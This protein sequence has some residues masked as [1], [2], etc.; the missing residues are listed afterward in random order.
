MI[1]IGKLNNMVFHPLTPAQ[2]V[3]HHKREA[4]RLRQMAASEFAAENMM[5][6]CPETSGMSMELLERIEARMPKKD[7]KTNTEEKS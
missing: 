2:A 1:S 6:I 5:G 3:Q 7:K 4:L